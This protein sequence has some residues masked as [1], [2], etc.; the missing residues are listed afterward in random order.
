MKTRWIIK[1]KKGRF[2]ESMGD[3]NA[4]FNSWVSK[5]KL[6]TRKKKARFFMDRYKLNA[7]IL[8]VELIKEDYEKINIIN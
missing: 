6:F 5:A 7:D 4:M 2:V 1:S 3:G 8:K